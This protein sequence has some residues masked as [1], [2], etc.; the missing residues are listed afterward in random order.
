MIGGLVVRSQIGDQ[1]RAPKPVGPERNQHGENK[2]GS[3]TPTS[4]HVCGQCGARFGSA[5]AL[6]GHKMVRGH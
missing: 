1:A 3:S 4:P 2:L 6:A 5:V